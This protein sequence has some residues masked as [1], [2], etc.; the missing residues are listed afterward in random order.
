MLRVRH[1]A[2]AAV[3][4]S[5]AL[6]TVF[7]DLA[8]FVLVALVVF[9][10]MIVAALAAI[11]VIKQVYVVVQIDEERARLQTIAP[12]SDVST[13]VSSVIK[14]RPPII[15]VVIMLPFLEVD[16]LI[17]RLTKLNQS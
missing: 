5:N 14:G 11:A 4:K 3:K 16:S 1:A 10:P 12:Q 15:L 17:L 2:R 9:A 6:T 13:C 7:R 8:D